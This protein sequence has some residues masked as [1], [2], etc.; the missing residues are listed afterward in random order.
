MNTKSIYILFLVLGIASI[1]VYSQSTNQN[2]I[3]TRTYT[4]E[5]GSTYLEQVQYFDGL[6]RPMQMVQKAITPG[7]DPS[8]RKDLIILQEYDGFGRE[9]KAWLPAAIGGN[10]G[11]YVTPATVKTQAIATNG[12]DQKP[13]SMP[14]YESSPLNRVL[15]QFS[16]GQDW[17][18]NS[19]SVETA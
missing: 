15:K 4:N 2:Y 3:L 7:T 12:G 17:H 14:V 16:P 11:A 18:N 10:N 13:Y 1:N 19:K 9:D 8:A 6:G 5:T